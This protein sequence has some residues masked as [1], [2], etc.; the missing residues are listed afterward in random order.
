M[1]TE[2]DAFVVE[3]KV[4]MHLD[5]LELA[6]AERYCVSDVIDIDG[7]SP[8]VACEAADGACSAGRTRA[9]QSRSSRCSTA[10]T[11]SCSQARLTDSIA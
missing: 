1:D 2:D 3:F 6:I 7:A 8:D 9:P 11:P 4:P 5:D 10:T